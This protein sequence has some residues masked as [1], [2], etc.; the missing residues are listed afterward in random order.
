MSGPFPS[1]R[2]K[3]RHHKLINA[4]A[5]IHSYD[6]MAFSGR[7]RKQTARRPFVPAYRAGYF[8]GAGVCGEAGVA[9]GADAA[10]ALAAGAFGCAPAF[11]ACG[12]AFGLIQQ[13]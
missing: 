6:A 3:L 10:G 7:Q 8:A 2:Q 5:I 13:A 11:A 9:A 1:I 12:W 4:T